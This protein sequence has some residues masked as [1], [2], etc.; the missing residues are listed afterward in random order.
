[1]LDHGAG[2]LRTLPPATAETLASLRNAS[3]SLGVAW[4][5]GTSY[6]D[7]VRTLDPARPRDAAMMVA[8]SRTLRG[9]GYVTFD[10]TATDRLAG[11]VPVHA[12][13]AAPYA[14]VT[15]PLR[16]LVDRFGTECVLAGSA[17]RRP[18]GWV[19]DA[20]P[21]LADEMERATGRASAVDRACVD[22]VEAA[23]LAHRQGELLPAAVTSLRKDGEAVVQLAEPAVIAVATAPVGTRAGDAVLVRVLRA[24]P[25]TRSLQLEVV[26]PATPG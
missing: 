11:D 25:A 2:V 19:L 20:L 6:P 23:V 13:I 8:A 22:L 3:I 5:D 24:D 1:M 10:G 14:H 21:T 12:A 7:W 26:G 9:A 15:A 16:R 17:G 18:P 4:P